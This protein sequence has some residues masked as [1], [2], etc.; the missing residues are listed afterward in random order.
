MPPDGRTPLSQIEI[1][2]AEAFEF[3][4]AVSLTLPALTTFSPA[5]LKQI[6]GC[7]LHECK[8]KRGGGGASTLLSSSLQLKQWDA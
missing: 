8:E 5:F 4:S 1:I 7:D 6:S 2:P 3:I